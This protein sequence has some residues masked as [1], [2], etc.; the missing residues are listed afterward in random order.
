MRLMSFV[1][2]FAAVIGFTNA[3][4]IGILLPDISRSQLLFNQRM[5][6]V[7]ADAGHNVTLIRLQ[8]LEN[9]GKDIKIATRP[10]MVEWKV[11]G[12]LDEIDYDWIK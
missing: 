2:F 12:F 10:G 1:I 11:D 9:D 7:L 3:Y 8:T 6:E 5:G 4:K